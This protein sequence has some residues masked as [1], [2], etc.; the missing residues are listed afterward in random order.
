MTGYPFYL[1]RTE[2]CT[3]YGMVWYGMVWYGFSLHYTN[4]NITNELML[5]AFHAIT[6]LHN[7]HAK[8]L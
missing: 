4:I 5:F 8:I 6:T 3:W 2:I 7:Y 1:H